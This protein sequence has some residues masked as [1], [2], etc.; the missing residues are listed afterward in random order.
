MKNILSFKSFKIFNNFI[1]KKSIFIF[2]ICIKISIG[3]NGMEQ[4]IS[5]IQ[6]QISNL[7]EE[8]PELELNGLKLNFINNLVNPIMRITEELADLT[9]KIG[10]T[11][12]TKIQI[13]QAE[14]LLGQLQKLAD[15]F[16]Q[17]KM[18]LKTLLQQTN[19][20]KETIKLWNQI[21]A[22]EK[23]KQAIWYQ[24]ITIINNIKEKN[25]QETKKIFTKT[26]CWWNNKEKQTANFWDGIFE[27]N[28]INNML[29]Q[30]NLMKKWIEELIEH[31]IPTNEFIEKLSF[32][33]DKNI[34][35]TTKERTKKYLSNFI[36]T[37]KREPRITKSVFI[38]TL[39]Y[40]DRYTEKNPS[41][42]SSQDISTIFV[43][44]FIVA[45]N[46]LLDDSLW[47][48]QIALLMN[49]N[50]NDKNL[51]RYVN[52]LKKRQKNFLDAIEFNLFISQEEY[53]AFEKRLN[54]DYQAFKAK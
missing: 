22:L 16:N 8:Q 52:E 50:L 23:Q 33:F 6:E 11:E 39:V 15:P 37:I 4:S 5:G 47:I 51:K 30:T 20:P 42:W 27:Q 53:E 24:I 41:F 14:I 26:K 49:G 19:K 34:N 28:Q 2:L 21:Y 9:N 40:L 38:S 1:H 29:A 12:P 43:A 7:T 17:I 35:N 13:A 54:E 46:M 48:K 32:Y 10:T 45:N 31:Q 25:L 36:N 3:L 44:A 18:D